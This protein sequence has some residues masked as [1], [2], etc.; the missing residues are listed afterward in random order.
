MGPQDNDFI[1]TFSLNLNGQLTSLQEPLVMGIC[2]INADS[3]YEGSRVHGIDEFITR[4][5]SLSLEGAQIIDIGIASS[6][7]GA[8]LIDAT[9]EISIAK[10][11]LEELNKQLPH[12]TF[13]LDTYN[14]ST[15]DLA[16]QFGA[17]IINDISG[18]NIDP[19]MLTT[20]ANGNVGYVAMHMKGTPK[21][22]QNQPQ[23]DD[24][25]KDVIYALS[26]VKN[27]CEQ[28][29]I[30]DVIIDPGFGFGK[31]VAHNYELFNNL[32]HFK[33]L[34]TP[35]LVG[36][37]RKSM[38]YKPLNITPKDAL[39]ATAALHLKALEN[40]VNILRVH[41]VKEAV[42]IIEIHKLLKDA[43]TD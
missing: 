32:D 42:Q 6:R 30:S 40:G 34:D 10:P 33:V 26:E 18:G 37:S 4:C 39:S 22:M 24:V 20:V 19:N 1:S 14:A 27:R 15:A 2:N 11:Y 16:I 29:G 7:P 3:F 5:E 41:D 38:I 12:L 8:S 28:A 36:I 31:S 43:R 25:T 35:I 9:E 23:Y 13:S 21:T 17:A